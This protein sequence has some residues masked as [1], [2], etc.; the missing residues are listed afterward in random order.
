M[1]QRYIGFNW[2]LNQQSVSLLDGKLIAIKVLL[3]SWLTLHSR[4]SAHCAL[5]LHGKL[6]HVSCI[7]PLIQPFLH[8][9][10]HFAGDFKSL[11]TKLHPPH[12]VVAD[13][14]WVQQIMCNVLNTIPLSYLNQ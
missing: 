6:V 7:Y 9:L 5:S 4:Y 10:S 1:I 14:E 12:A 2:D 3:D 11:V 13:L 8:S